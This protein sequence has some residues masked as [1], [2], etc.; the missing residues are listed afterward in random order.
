MSKDHRQTILVPPEYFFAVISA[1]AHSNLSISL[2][3]RTI[4]GYP[5]VK[6]ACMVVLSEA[7]R[8]CHSSILSIMKLDQ[9]MIHVRVN[10]QLFY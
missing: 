5:D 2:T 1:N 10:L 7:T 3:Q 4:K 8:M 6:D 9:N